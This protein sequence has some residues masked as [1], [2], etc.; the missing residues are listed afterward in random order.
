MST[1]LKQVV[2]LRQVSGEAR[3]RDGARERSE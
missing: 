3:V 1:F 2:L